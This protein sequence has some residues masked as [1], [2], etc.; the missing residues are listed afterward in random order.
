MTTFTRSHPKLC[1]LTTHFSAATRQSPLF[2]PFYPLFLA[3]HGLFPS[4]Y[5]SFLRTIRM[6]RNRVQHVTQSHSETKPDISA[7]LPQ[8]NICCP[9]PHLKCPP[10]KF[11]FPPQLNSCLLPPLPAH[12]QNVTD[13]PST[14]D[15][16]TFNH[17]AD[18]H[19]FHSTN[20]YF[21]PIHTI[22]QALGWMNYSP[23]LLS[24]S[25]TNLILPLIIQ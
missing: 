12:Y 11:T 1:A 5:H 22:F 4:H 14:C 16:I 17:K 2:S 8:W 19:N 23:P 18:C 24:T 3:H 6:W 7:K 15:G 9:P 21:L 13:L 20:S 25:H 10:S